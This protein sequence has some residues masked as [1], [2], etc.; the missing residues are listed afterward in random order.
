MAEDSTMA[1]AIKEEL[2][3]EQMIATAPELLEAAKDL[4]KHLSE[5]EN[6]KWLTNRPGELLIKAIARI[7]RFKKTFDI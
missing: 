5:L 3:Y 4:V 2:A 1:I 7:D 6:G